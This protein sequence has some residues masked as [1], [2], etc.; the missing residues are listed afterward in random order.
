LVQSIQVEVGEPRTQ[1]TSNNRAKLPLEFSSSIEREELKVRYGEGFGGAP[2][3]LP[4][5]THRLA[6]GAED[7]SDEQTQEQRSTIV[8]GN[9]HV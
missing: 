8:G 6:T 9:D 2:L 5:T 7:S 1:Y 4:S 3:R